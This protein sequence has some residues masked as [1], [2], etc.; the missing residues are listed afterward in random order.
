MTPPTAKT[1][2]NARD[3]YAR[4]IMMDGWGEEGQRRLARSTVL[5]AGAGGL[6][7]PASLYLAAAGVGHLRVCDF[8]AVD[9]SNLNRQVLH[10][11][12]RIGMGKAAS[13]RMTLSELNPD[14][15]VAPLSLKI[16]ET[17]VAEVVGDADVIIDAM[18]NFPTRYV[19]NDCAMRQGIPLVHGSVWG[20][21]GRLT[22]LHPPR[23]PCLRCLFPEAPPRE[24]FPVAG[25]TPGVIGCLQ[26]L[27]AL[28]YLT[29]VGKLMEGRMLAWDGALMEFQTVS[30]SRDPLCAACGDTSRR[31]T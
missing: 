15:R 5:V 9:W 12:S 8:D 17:N 4:Q 27:E 1:A 2:S 28:K 24:V 21:D 29:G 30:V 10:D 19:L 7:S 3:R 26:A 25:P 11:P 23:T 18:D 16:D 22:F 14:V 31:K 20:M 6:G 13:A